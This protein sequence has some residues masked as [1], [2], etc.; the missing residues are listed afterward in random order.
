MAV[1]QDGQI[2]FTVLK[3]P[4][5]EDGV[6]VDHILGCARPEW[7]GDQPVSLPGSAPPESAG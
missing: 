6:A 1:G 5:V 3:L 4:C 7:P 2:R